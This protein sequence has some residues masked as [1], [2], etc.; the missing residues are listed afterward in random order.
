MRVAIEIVG[1]IALRLDQPTGGVGRYING[2]LNQ[3]E[4]HYTAK[5]LRLLQI[6]VVAAVIITY[7]FEPNRQENEPHDA[8]DNYNPGVPA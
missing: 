3:F 6:Q 8:K 1:P 2:L 5:K 7:L 4:A